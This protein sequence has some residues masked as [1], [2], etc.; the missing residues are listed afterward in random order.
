MIGDNAIITAG[1]VVAG[2]TKIGKNFLTGGNSS[3]TGHIE[4]CDNVQLAALSGVRKA[5][6]KPGAYG[7]NPLMPMREYMRMASALMKLPNLIAKFRNELG[8]EDE[9][10]GTDF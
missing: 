9:S 1:F 3:V 2:S 10:E 4:I 5:I 7:G 6:T 8:D